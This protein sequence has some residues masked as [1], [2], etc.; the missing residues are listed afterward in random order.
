V[1]LDDASA[2]ASVHRRDILQETFSRT[3]E[4]TFPDILPGFSL[5]VGKLFQ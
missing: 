5:V 2:T 4:L 1:V 3:D